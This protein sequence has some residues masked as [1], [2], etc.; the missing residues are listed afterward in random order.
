[1]AQC[2]QVLSLQPRAASAQRDDV[3]YLSSHRRLTDAAH[4]LFAAHHDTELLP[5]RVVPAPGRVGPPVG[6]SR[7]GRALWAMGGKTTLAPAGRTN[8]HDLFYVRRGRHRR[9]GAA[10]VPALNYP[11]FPDGWRQPSGHC[12]AKR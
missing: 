10:Q 6:R 11:G 8:G 4:G 2:L 3:I 1:M 12:T 7:T 5:S 9:P